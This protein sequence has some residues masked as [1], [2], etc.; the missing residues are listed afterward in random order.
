MLRLL[1][2]ERWIDELAAAFA[3]AVR[4][5]AA[6]ARPEMQRTT[7]RSVQLDHDCRRVFPGSERRA[8]TPT[9]SGGTLGEA[10]AQA[11]RCG[12]LSSVCLACVGAP[13]RWESKGV[14]PTRSILRVQ[15]AQR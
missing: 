6:S 12:F 7:T 10:Y 15:A 14:Q 5:T 3:T 13:T 8:P 11:Q 4:V 1:Q 2:H 9:G